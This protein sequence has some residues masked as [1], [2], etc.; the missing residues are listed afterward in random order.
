MSAYP[1]SQLSEYSSLSP[2]INNTKYKCVFFLCVRIFSNR[3]TRLVSRILEQSHK[4]TPQSSKLTKSYDRTSYR[5]LKW[6]PTPLHDVTWGSLLLK[7]PTNRLFVQCPV[8]AN[9]RSSVLLAHRVNSHR[10]GPV[11]RKAFPYYVALREN[12]PTKIKQNNGLPFHRLSRTFFFAATWYACCETWLHSRVAWWGHQMETF[13]AL[14]VRVT[15]ASGAELW[16]FL[17]SA[18]EQTVVQTID[19]PVIWDAIAL[20]M[21]LKILIVHGTKIHVS[22]FQLRIPNNCCVTKA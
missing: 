1:P 13:S 3:L 21:T 12:E 9:D 22:K 10:K 4:T 19:T 14:L 5:I 11:M 2:I 16:C 7:L 18:P 15:K 8:Q 17:W 6:P 20:I